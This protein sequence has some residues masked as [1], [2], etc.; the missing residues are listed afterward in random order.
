MLHATGHPLGAEMLGGPDLSIRR[1]GRG[2]KRRSNDEH[3]SERQMSHRVVSLK[4]FWR[5]APETGT[6]RPSGRRPRRPAQE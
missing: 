2:T 6:G 4:Q 5:C 1:A 3:C